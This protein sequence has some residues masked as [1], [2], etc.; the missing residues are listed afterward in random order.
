MGPLVRDAEALMGALT[1]PL[2]RL[3][4]HPLALARFGLLALRS[5]GGL[6]TST[7]AGER[8]RGLFAGLGTHAMLPLEWSPGAG[9]ALVMALLGH[10]VGWPMAR[11]GSQ[12][13]ADALASYLR[14]LGGRITTG[15][16]VDSLDDLPPAR[17]TLLEV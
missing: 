11:G 13:V 15:R 4:R 1:G 7:F 2:V 3:P 14:S 9:F 10:V 8:A 12:R 17:A 6:A 16:V 5:A